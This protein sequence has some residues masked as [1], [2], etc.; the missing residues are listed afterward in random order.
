MAY[1]KV[2][3]NNKTLIDLTSDTVTPANLLW[4]AKAHNAAGVSITGTLFQ[5]YPETQSFTEPITDST[6]IQISGS[7]NS[8]LE[9]VVIYKRV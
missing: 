9:G 4:K 7:G 5:N 6:G 8:K 2:I 3:Y 1:N